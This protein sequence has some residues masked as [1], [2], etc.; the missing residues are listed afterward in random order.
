MIGEAAEQSLENRNLENGEQGLLIPL[1]A[2]SEE[3]S[4]RE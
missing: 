1:E 2:H 4:P 3:D